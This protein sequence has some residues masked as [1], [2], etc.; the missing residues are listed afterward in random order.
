MLHR[1]VEMIGYF[2]SLAQMTRDIVVNWKRIVALATFQYR[3]NTKDMFLGGLW[4][5]LSPFIQIGAYWLVF[6]I[7]L[8]SGEPVDG[9][10]YVVW[11]TCGVTPWFWLSGGVS[12]AASSIY[13]KA[14]MLTRSNIPTC[15]I[16]LSF[17]LANTFD[18]LWTVALM[19]VIYLGNGCLPTLSAL[20]LIYY[21][22]CGLAFL[23][24][25]SL[26]TSTLVMLARDFQ[27]VIQAVMRLI[28]FLSPVFW[29]PGRT[30]PEAFQ[31]FD[32]CNPFGYIIRGFRNCLLYNVSIFENWRQGIIFWLIVAVLY[33]IGSAF[34]SKMRKNL[35]DY[36]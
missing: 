2:S 5:L 16:P 34:Q 12:R 25:V 15:L 7:G 29:L 23:S 30:L 36:L 14:S 32:Y 3:L 21:V 8:R 28:F 33:L 6:G 20:W 31:L 24:A 22:I 18:N 27:K 10:P 35:L 1:S 4:K 19:V 26:I 17:V 11:L 13:S 9:I